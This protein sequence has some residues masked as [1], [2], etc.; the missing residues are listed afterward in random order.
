MRRGTII[1]SMIYTLERYCA[2]YVL[3]CCKLIRRHDPDCFVVLG[4]AV[5]LVPDIFLLAIAVTFLE[6]M[7]T[8]VICYCCYKLLCNYFIFNCL[9]QRYNIFYYHQTIS[10]IA[11]ERY[12][13]LSNVRNFDRCRCFILTGTE[14]FYKS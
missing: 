13:S 5:A 7:F 6:E 4:K 8:L 11:I 1:L 12:Y 3:S 10:S 14:T 2:E 9:S